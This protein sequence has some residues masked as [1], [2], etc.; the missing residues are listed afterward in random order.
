MEV[1][2]FHKNSLALKSFWLRARYDSQAQPPE[3]F[4]KKLFL[5]IVQNSEENTWLRPAS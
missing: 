3:A 1:L 4:C 2:L 5:D